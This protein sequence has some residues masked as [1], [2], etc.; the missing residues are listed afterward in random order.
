MST[1]LRQVQLTGGGA[2][3]VATVDMLMRAAF[4]P[5]YGEAWTQGQCLG[6]LAMPGVWLTLAHIDERPVGFAL[7]RV[8]ADEAELLLLATDPGARRRGAGG[9]L[10]RSV[11]DDARARRAARLHLEV[12]AGNGAVAL[13]GAHGLEKV[14]ERREYYRGADGKRRDAHTYAVEL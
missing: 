7:A 1:L 3:D 5:K 12:R 6:V 11:M 9:A 10:L 4:D 13:Y 8:V 14:G 2:R